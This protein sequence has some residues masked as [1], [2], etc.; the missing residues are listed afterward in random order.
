MRQPLDLVDVVVG[1]QLARSAVR[2]VGQRVD[3]GQRLPI[4][5]FDRPAGRLDRGNAGCGW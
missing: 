2:E 1:D 4:E 5:R 3:P